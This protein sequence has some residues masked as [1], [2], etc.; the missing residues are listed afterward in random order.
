MFR[1]SGSY[2]PGLR[3]GPL[4]RVLGPAS[5]ALAALV[6][7]VLGP[8]SSAA[9]APVASSGF[10]I[11]QIATAPAGA[12]N[13][14]DITLLDGDL[15]VTCQ[16]ATQSTGGGGNSTIV[17][18]AGDGSIANTFSLP[19]KA[20][21]IG[22]D[23]LNHR[24]IVTF[25][26]DGNSHL[27]TIKPSAP[28]GSQVVNYTYSPVPDSI[29]GS[30]PLHTGGG[31][32]AVTVDDAGNI[33]ITA[34]A[35]SNPAGTAVFKVALGPSSGA[36][37]TATLS[38]TF[39]DNATA[40]NGN[41][42]TGTTT[43]ALTDPDSNAVVPSESPFYGGQ[44]VLGD[45]TSNQLVFAS[46]INAAGGGTLTA[47][48]LTRSGTPT[49]VDDIRWSTDDHGTL[50]VVDHGTGGASVLYKVTGPFV[51][52]T[53][54]AASATEI[55]TVDLAPGANAGVLSPFV[56]G[57]VA[58]KGLWYGASHD[59]GHD[60]G[61]DGGDDGGHGRGDHRGNHD[62]GAHHGERHTR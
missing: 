40:N 61:H 22:A 21:G 53:A 33:L 4:A 32:D 55:D 44:F 25:N 50:Y 27:A 46:A 39:L 3:R 30:G 23:P 18:Y 28:A 47:L 60:G 17:E 13:C 34:S 11:T 56:T 12:S 9:A 20:D 31:T 7:A 52:G 19:D 29:G 45:Q 26:E 10:T 8:A 59:R 5:A 54:Y 24:L 48:N 36:A 1:P 58:P 62:G 42:G 57:L 35:P 38:R 6:V 43:L 49:A 16:N 14:D 37:G 15:F 51:P 41:T 2:D